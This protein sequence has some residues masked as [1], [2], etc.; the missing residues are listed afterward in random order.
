MDE[1]RDV[2][3]ILATML[4]DGLLII[5]PIVI[6]RSAHLDSGLQLRLMAAVSISAVATIFVVIH[7]ALSLTIGG[8]LAA[9][10]AV[11]EVRISL[12]CFAGLTSSRL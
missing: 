12:N 8:L 10:F 7:F 6:L 5:S 2:Y 1:L 9:I 4:T 11:I 3:M